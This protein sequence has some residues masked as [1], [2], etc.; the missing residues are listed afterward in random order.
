MATIWN[1]VKYQENLI[2]PRFEK[3]KSGTQWTIFI[4]GKH[5]LKR[6][7]GINFRSIVLSYVDQRY[8]KWIIIKFKAIFRWNLT[9]SF[10]L[11][12]NISTININEE[13]K[14][15]MF[16]LLSGKWVSIQTQLTST[17]G[18]RFSQKTMLPYN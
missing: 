9:F 5:Y 3:T 1:K 7:S 16:W 2:F 14:K 11:Q 4:L 13:L 8:I 15:K 17:W 6:D 18:D 10:C 12:L